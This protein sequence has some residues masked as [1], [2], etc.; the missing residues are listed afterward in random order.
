[1]YPPLP[2]GL[3][4]RTKTG[5]ASEN[6]HMASQ[7]KRWIAPSLSAPHGYTATSEQMVTWLKNRNPHFYGS[8]FQLEMLVMSFPIGE[9]V[10]KHPGPDEVPPLRTL[11]TWDEWFLVNSTEQRRWF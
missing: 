3:G 6:D 1:M 7:D 4:K 2:E 8:W 10:K 11:P 9:Y 5:L